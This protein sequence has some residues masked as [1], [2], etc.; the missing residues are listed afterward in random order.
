LREFRLR[1]IG[2]L[3]Y[4]KPVRRRFLSDDRNVEVNT[5][6]FKKLERRINKILIEVRNKTYRIKSRRR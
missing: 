2:R 1:S 5:L 3:R 6:K 4:I